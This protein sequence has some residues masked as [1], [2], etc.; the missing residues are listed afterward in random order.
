MNGSFVALKGQLTVIDLYW[1]LVVTICYYREYPPKQQKYHNLT[2]KR[3]TKPYGS[4][5]SIKRRKCK[6]YC[7]YK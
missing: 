1:G 2:E 4:G 6:S 3:G 7:P 5:R